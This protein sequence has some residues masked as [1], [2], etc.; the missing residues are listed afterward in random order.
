MTRHAW[1]KLRTHNYLCRKCGT[2]KRNEQSEGGEWSATY[3][4]PD[5]SVV[6]SSRVPSC[7]PGKLTIE[8]LEWLRGHD[9]RERELT[10][11][12]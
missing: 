4:R 2:G 6:I 5:G 12:A 7:E 1:T 11:R 9:E 10:P 3:H 8:R